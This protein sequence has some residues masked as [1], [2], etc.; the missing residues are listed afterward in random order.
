[1]DFLYKQYDLFYF[2]ALSLVPKTRDLTY[3]LSSELLQKWCFNLNR[4]DPSYELKK[5]VS[6]NIDQV[7]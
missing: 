1:M 6:N 2:Y 4:Q 3:T 5:V 7:D